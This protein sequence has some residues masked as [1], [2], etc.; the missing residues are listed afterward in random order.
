MAVASLCDCGFVLQY[1]ECRGCLLLD[2][3]DSGGIRAIYGAVGAG[4][5]T[6]FVNFL[7]C[8]RGKLA[9]D[10]LEGRDHTPSQFEY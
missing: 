4:S 9:R 2:D 1:D 7:R 3:I 10:V 8:L 5:G 6:Q